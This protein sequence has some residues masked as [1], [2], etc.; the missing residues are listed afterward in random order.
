MADRPISSTSPDSL[1]WQLM[2]MLKDQQRGDGIP[3]LPWGP[4]H[5]GV[6][7]DEVAEALIMMVNIRVVASKV[8][9]GEEVRAFMG[10]AID[11]TVNS[12]PDDSSGGQFS[13]VL[14]HHGPNPYLLA[15]ELNYVASSTVDDATV[16]EYALVIDK[17]AA[18]ISKSTN[19]AAAA[20]A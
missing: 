19:S 8:K 13:P 16:A 6:R 11:D 5:H 9:G 12:I 20:T 7:R 10:R 17:L 2:T 1:Y 3:P 4:K 15:A 14:P 18:K